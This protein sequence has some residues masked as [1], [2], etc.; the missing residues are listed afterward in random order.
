VKTLHPYLRFPAGI[1]ILTSLFSL[2]VYLTGSILIYQAGLSCMLVYLAYLVFLEI[3]LISLHCPNCF[4]YNRI[5]AFGKGKLSGIFFKKGQATKF[6]CKKFTWK[7]MIPDMLVFLVPF[8][9]GI[10]A[11]ITDFRWPILILLILFMILNFSGNAYVRG[12]LACNHCKQGEIG[13][14]ALELFH[15]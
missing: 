3:R 7:N 9:V 14:P 13:C 6:S 1:V 8:L 15:K 10:V 5:C 12:H 4:Y 2:S 11:L